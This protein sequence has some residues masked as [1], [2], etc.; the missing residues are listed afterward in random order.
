MK[1]DIGGP[2]EL[3]DRLGSNL[4]DRLNRNLWGDPWHSLRMGLWNRL[5]TSLHAGLRVS[6]TRIIRQGYSNEP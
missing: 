3:R 2:V 1:R 6:F 5:Y 4:T